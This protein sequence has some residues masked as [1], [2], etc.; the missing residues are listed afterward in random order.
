[1]AAEDLFDSLTV[2][3]TP[4]TIPPYQ[5]KMVDLPSGGRVGLRVKSKSGEPTMDVDIPGIPIKKIKFV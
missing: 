4:V 5:G 2:G 1:M 3:G